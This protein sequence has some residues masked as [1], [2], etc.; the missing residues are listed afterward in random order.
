MNKSDAK[1][2]MP[3]IQALHEGKTIQTNEGY[4]IWYDLENVSFSYPPSSYRIKPEPKLRPWKPE[5]VPVGAQIRQKGFNSRVLIFGVDENSG[6][7]LIFCSGKI[8]WATAKY[9]L[10]KDEHSTDNGKTWKPCG[11]EE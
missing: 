3:L 1:D 10:E 2:Y 4:G 8:D 9:L 6:D 5:E 11:V 7:A